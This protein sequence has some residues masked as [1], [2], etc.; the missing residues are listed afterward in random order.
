MGRYRN[1]ALLND[2][3]DK[4]ECGEVYNTTEEGVNRQKL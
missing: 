4:V 3:L 1:F 2:S